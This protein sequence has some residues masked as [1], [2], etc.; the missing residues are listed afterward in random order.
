MRITCAPKVVKPVAVNETVEVD[1]VEV[2]P[3][4]AN[5]CPGVGIC[6]SAF[7]VCEMCPR[8]HM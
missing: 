3:L 1:G 4:D 6:A 7:L 8:W 2:T 5:H